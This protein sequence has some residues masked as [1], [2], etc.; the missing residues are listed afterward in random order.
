MA[1]LRSSVGSFCL[2]LG[3]HVAMRVET[4][5][6]LSLIQKLRPFDCG[7]ELIR[8]GGPGDGG[9]LI[10]NDLEGV[11]YCF[12]PGVGG[13]CAFENQLANL[14]IKSFMADYSVDGPPV[15]RPEFTFDKK[16]VGA[17]DSERFMT[18]AFWKE[19]Y[20]KDYAGELVLEMDVEG[21]EYGVILNMP[22]ALLYQFRI[23]AIEFHDL[24]LLFERSAFPLIS[25][26]FEKILRNFCVVHIHPNNCRPPVKCGKIEIPRVLEFT[27]L[28]RR[29]V[30]STRPRS[31]F[32]HKLD[33][34]SEQRPPLP[35]PACWYS[36]SNGGEPK[37][38]PIAGTSR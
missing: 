10:P 4:Q 5:E 15:S 27:F 1:R 24:D 8:V 20:L 9:Y 33:F 30:A 14:G 22:D 32:P 36:P 35:L 7:K 17:Y 16:F 13:N 12:S 29:R 11:E 31:D 23:M 38:G 34:E 26:C 21:S 2:G 6:V 28:N 25:S 19:K 37:Y 3:F 18:M